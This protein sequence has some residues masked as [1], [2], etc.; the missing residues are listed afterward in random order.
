MGFGKC[1]I[2]KGSYTKACILYTTFFDRDEVMA[3]NAAM[4][5]KK[6]LAF[7]YKTSFFLCFLLSEVVLSTE[8]PPITPEFHYLKYFHTLQSLSF[9][10]K[11][12][13]SEESIVDSRNFSTSSLNGCL[14]QPS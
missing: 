4:F 13:N 14:H 1:L 2:L 12:V 6:I 11:A 9:Q 8:E 3:V 10:F 5:V 7:L